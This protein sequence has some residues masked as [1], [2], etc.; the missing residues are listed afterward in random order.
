M[1]SKA[2]QKQNNGITQN[3]AM[4]YLKTIWPKAPDVEVEKAGMLCYQYGLNPLLK[5]VYL[6]QFGQEW[7]TVLGIKATR[8]LAQRNHSYGFIDGPRFMTADEQTTIFGKS[9][10]DR[11]YAICKIKDSQG[12]VY[13]G[14]GWWP[15]NKTVHG[16]DKGNSELNMAFIRAERNALDKMAP[17][18]L[19]EADV[20]DDTYQVVDVKAAIEAGKKEMIAEA[21]E[22]IDTLW[23]KPGD[24]LSRA[25]TKEEL[26]TLGGARKKAGK[27]GADGWPIPST[28]Q[29][30][31][32]WAFSHGKTYNP[33]WTC[34]QLN[35]NSTTEI[36]DIK[37]AYLALKQITGW[38]D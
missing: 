18:E 29:D 21:K 26:T 12:N 19:P 28:V 24:E 35:V 9:Y 15:A 5:Q 27:S 16:A 10:P 30:L 7:V 33:T 14:Y 22:D 31:M 6:V 1:D 25:A 20:V 4:Y 37:T 38:S 3:K 36:K 13:P 11:I 23:D 34:H 17:G 2:L 32:K 8:Q